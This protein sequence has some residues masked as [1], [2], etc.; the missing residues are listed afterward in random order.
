MVSWILTLLLLTG[1]SPKTSDEVKPSVPRRATGTAVALVPGVLVSGGGHLITGDSEGAAKMLKLKGIGLGTLAAGFIPIV[2]ANAPDKVM[3]WSYPVALAGFGLFSTATLAD[4][5]GALSGGQ[6]LGVPDTTTPTL[7][8][9]QQIL[10]VKDPHFS[11]RL[12]SHTGITARW[13][14]LSLHTDVFTGLDS[15]N[16]RIGQ[17]L[18]WRM[19]G[20]KPDHSHSSAKNGSFL[21]LQAKG[22]WHRFPEERFS[23]T[24]GEL[25]LL[26]RMDLDVWHRTLAGSFVQAGMGWAMEWTGFEDSPFASESSILQL[27]EFAYGVYLGSAPRSGELHVYYSHRNDDWAGGISTV[28]GFFGVRG[29][30]FFHRN[31]GLDARMEKGSATRLQLGLVVVY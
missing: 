16:L 5:Y 31:F 9:T 1:T 14:F 4:L 7:E 28:M 13:H 20:P 27:F 17:A 22:T 10:R 11:T 29:R 30:F 3:N 15:E 8:F 23:V 21:E 26:G 25:F 24:T 19:N 6:A 12:F 18:A 2:L